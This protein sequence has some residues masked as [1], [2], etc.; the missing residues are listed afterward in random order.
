MKKVLHIEFRSMPFP[1]DL[2]HEMASAPAHAF[3]RGVA[4]I[5]ASVVK[6]IVETA[7]LS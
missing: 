7:S 1:Q 2:S 6:S 5:M 3:A 4:T